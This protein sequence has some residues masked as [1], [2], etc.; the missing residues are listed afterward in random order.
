MY[1]LGIN[2]AWHDSA[3]CLMRDGDVIAAAEEERFTQVKHHKVTKPETSYALPFHAIDY[4]LGAA[5]ITLTQ[6]DHVAYAM[7]PLIL[8]EG[9]TRTP[10]FELPSNRPTLNTPPGYD[11]WET[12]FM[13]GV[14][15]APRFLLQD[16]P[17]H[18][19]PRF[20][21]ES[22]KHRWEF[23]FVEHHIAHAASAFLPSPFDRAAILCLDGAGEKVTT[24]MGAGRGT[25]IEKLQEVKMPHSLGKFYEMV[26]WYLGFLP[27]SDEYKVMALASYGKPRYADQF[28]TLVRF[29]GDGRFEI[30]PVYEVL[31]KVCAP[32]RERRE[33]FETRH[34]DIAA[35]LQTVLEEA[36]LNLAG[37][38]HERT[39]EKDLCM[40]GGVALNC[41]M[42]S[43]LV[44]ESRF[45]RIWVQPAAG[46]A[47]AA[48]GAAMWLWT[49]KGGANGGRWRMHDAYLGPEYDDKVIGGVL[50]HG[51]LPYRHCE[52][53]AGAAAECIAQ[54][55]VVGWFQG[56]ME[57]G[58]RA[59]GARSILATPADP[60]MV[61]R[62]NQLKDREDFRPVA[63]AVLEEAAADYFENCGDAPFML[64]VYR[65]R[66]DKAA[67]VPAI[68]HVDGTARVQTVSAARAPLFHRVISR[69]QDITGLPVVVN[70]SF[71]TRG[72]PIVC[73]PRDALECFYTSPID[74]LAIG[75]YLLTK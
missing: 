67:L 29:L 1:I 8:L 24:L 74:A 68:R 49:R 72:R 5:G 25:D 75:S 14:L 3:A 13:H 66:P 52:D 19:M 34:Y 33:P 17:Y 20:E 48:M 63:P 16:V 51:Q 23:H 27:S 9:R 38:L 37:W 2:A 15:S 58:P 40:A 10:R 35:S 61:E 22:P 7:D 26:T 44:R 32:R 54:G 64:F 59:L 6:V 43:R 57:F 60:G 39:G 11:A 21:I 4:C 73:T 45:E 46:D 36:C 65:V 53:I 42:N 71:N 62:L 28:R 50:K 56:R 69:F 18:L 31:E 30:G 12:I 47:G 70:T 41:V 55:K